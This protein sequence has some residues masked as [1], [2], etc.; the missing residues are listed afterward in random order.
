MERSGEGAGAG[1]T[2]RDEAGESEVGISTERLLNISGLI[3]S[4]SQVSQLPHTCPTDEGESVSDTTHLGGQYAGVPHWVPVVACDT[5]KIVKIVKIVNMCVLSLLAAAR[6]F[7][8][9][10]CYLG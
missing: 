8:R 1:G 7:Y 6:K 4:C 3:H 2:R 10:P 5:G 9:R